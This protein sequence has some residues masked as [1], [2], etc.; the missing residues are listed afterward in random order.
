MA[1]RS[2]KYYFKNEK[3]LMLELGLKPTKASGSGW[4]EKEDG[5]NDFVIAQLKSTDAQSIKINKLDLEKL[6]YNAYVCKKLPL[7]IIEFL[8]DHSIYFLVS[9]L[10]IPEMAEFIKYG[11]SNVDSHL[12]NSKGSD[13]IIGPQVNTI[14]TRQV[15]K[16]NSKKRDKYWR[17]KYG[18]GK[19]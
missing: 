17:D 18:T 3:Q 2:G 1:K 14:E 5:Q 7:F 10:D 8:N 13:S 11:P 15:I 16:S 12:N 4:V 6:E 9:P 19:D